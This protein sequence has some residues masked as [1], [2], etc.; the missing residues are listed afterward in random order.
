MEEGGHFIGR[1]EQHD[2]QAEDIQGSLACPITLYSLLQS[3]DMIGWGH[4]RAPSYSFFQNHWVY[5]MSPSS[6]FLNS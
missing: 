6:G 5:V 2:P 1:W 3:P 4:Y